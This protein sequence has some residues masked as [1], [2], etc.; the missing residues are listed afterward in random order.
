MTTW[1]GITMADTNIMK[2]KD[3]HF[4]LFLTSTQAASSATVLSF[5]KDSAATVDVRAS[6]NGST[7]WND[8]NSTY[9]SNVALS[10][11]TRYARIVVTAANGTATTTTVVKITVSAAANPTLGTVSG[12]TGGP[13]A[14][15]GAGHDLRPVVH[16]AAMAELSRSG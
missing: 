7:G 5:T 12:A 1:N 2:I 11:T 15:I 9:G 16:A 8:W 10:A 13:I 4:V 6:T 3:D 14:P